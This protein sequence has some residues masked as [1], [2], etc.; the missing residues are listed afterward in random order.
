MKKKGIKKKTLTTQ[1]LLK[2]KLEK[3]Q[4]SFI[5]GG[6]DDTLAFTDVNG[7]GNNPNGG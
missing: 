3:A 7:N 1:K 6:D 2:S 5:I 4:L